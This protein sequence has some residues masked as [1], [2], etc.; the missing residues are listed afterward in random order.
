MTAIYRERTV[1]LR[2]G[3]DRVACTC[4][5][6]VFPTNYAQGLFCFPLNDP[7]ICIHSKLNVFFL[8]SSCVPFLVIITF[9]NHALITR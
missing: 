5:G 9:D 1:V 6:T 7:K 2:L 4:T 8:R 3:V